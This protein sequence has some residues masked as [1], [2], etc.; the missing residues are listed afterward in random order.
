MAVA[1]VTQGTAI[2]FARFFGPFDPRLAVL[3]AIVLGGLGMCYPHT[4]QGFAIMWAPGDLRLGAHAS[5]PAMVLAC[6][7]VL[8]DVAAPLPVDSSITPPWA[9]LTYPDMGFINDMVM[10]AFPLALVLLILAGLR[11]RRA[12]GITL[13]SAFAVVA[14]CEAVFRILPALAGAT[15]CWSD[16]AVG[17]IVFAF[18]TVQFGIFRRHGYLAMCLARMDY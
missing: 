13:L 4:R 15:V 10:H 11:K 8:V 17:V 18:G 2:D 16:L 5:V 7:M 12:S 1:C 3:V 14:G 9:L 6:M